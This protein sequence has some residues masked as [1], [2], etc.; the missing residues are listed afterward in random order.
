MIAMAINNCG[1]MEHTMP[2]VRQIDIKKL[3]LMTPSI[4]REF[5]GK[6]LRTN[7]WTSFSSKLEFAIKDG[8]SVDVQSRIDARFITGKWE[9]YVIEFKICKK[10]K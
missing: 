1:E 3:C 2:E 9:R 5:V 7:D 4:P 6:R 10:R 8:R